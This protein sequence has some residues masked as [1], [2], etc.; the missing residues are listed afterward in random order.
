[1]LDL[2]PNHATESRVNKPRRTPR[3]RTHKTTNPL[4]PGRPRNGEGKGLMGRTAAARAIGCSIRTLMR[5]E[6]VQLMP[7]VKR[8]IHW[9]RPEDVERVRLKRATLPERVTKGGA[10]AAAL[11]ARFAAKQDL[12]TIVADLKVSPAAVRDAYAEYTTSLEE[13]AARAR[14]ERNQGVTINEQKLAAIAA[15][16][17]RKQELHERRLSDLD[18]RAL[19]RARL[20]SERKSA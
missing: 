7:T 13:G 4:A 1:M 8:G 18:A 12:P 15:E 16:E 9:F 11:F 19:Q 20:P 14:R 6:G 3:T 5:L 10:L 2:Q 17:R